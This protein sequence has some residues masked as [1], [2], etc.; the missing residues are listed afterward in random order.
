MD[1]GGSIKCYTSKELECLDD[2]Q[3]QKYTTLNVVS[4][5]NHIQIL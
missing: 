4:I 3:Q 5:L 2:N 1:K